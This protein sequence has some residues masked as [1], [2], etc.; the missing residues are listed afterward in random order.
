[1]GYLNLL[2]DY[3][4]HALLTYRKV[5]FRKDLSVLLVSELKLFKTVR[6]SLT[7]L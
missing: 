4:V 3:D 7:L 6:Q 5:K 1:M 2:T